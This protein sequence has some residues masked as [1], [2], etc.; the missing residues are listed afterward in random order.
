LGDPKEERFH[1][2]TSIAPGER[3]GHTDIALVRRVRLL[4]KRAPIA[5]SEPVNVL[6]IVDEK[7]WLAVSKELL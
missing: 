1:W 2:L 3:A 5:F 4:K 6:E 7:A